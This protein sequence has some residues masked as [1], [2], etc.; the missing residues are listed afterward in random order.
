MASSRPRFPLVVMAATGLAASVAIAL[1]AFGASTP[2]HR[3]PIAVVDPAEHNVHPDYDALLLEGWLDGETYFIRLTVE[4]VIQASGYMILVLAE[5]ADGNGRP[6]D[7]SLEY[8][9]GAEKNGASTLRDGGSLTFLFPLDRLIPN[10]YIVG[11]LSVLYGPETW[12][13]V[14]EAPR[15]SLDLKT[16]IETPFHPRLLW[17]ITVGLAVTSLVVLTKVFL[18]RE[19]RD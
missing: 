2:V 16:S 10:A 3:S 11:L 19:P 9:D 5:V 7:Y 13:M 12:D 15:D 14:K 1:L 6:H 4:G 18:V 17:L 8:V